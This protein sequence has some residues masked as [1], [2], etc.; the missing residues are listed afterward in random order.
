MVDP[1]SRALFSSSK[2]SPVATPPAPISS[3]PISGIGQTKA[4][5]LAKLRAQ[6]RKGR[7][8]LASLN[9]GG[10]AGALGKQTKRSGLGQLG[11][12]GLASELL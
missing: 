5:A 2:S 9:L 11:L 4:G 7:T 12:I 8:S 3:L 10:A 1:L 6:R